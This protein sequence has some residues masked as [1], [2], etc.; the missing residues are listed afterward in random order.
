ML[1]IQ[2][3]AYIILAVMADKEVE[4]HNAFS[5]WDCMG[6]VAMLAIFPA[7]VSFVFNDHDTKGV[8][9]WGA[10][11]AA[12]MGGIFLLSLIIKDKYLSK[13]VNIAGAVIT[14]FYTYWGFNAFMEDIK[15]FTD[16]PAAQKEKQ[17]NATE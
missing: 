16:D 15:K 8:I 4:D 11:A 13:I 2:A 12:A 17:D 3:S 7:V 10:V 5:R 14:L 6:A 1:Q 9:I